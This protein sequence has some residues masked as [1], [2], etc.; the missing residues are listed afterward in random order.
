VRVVPDEP[1]LER[2]FDYLADRPLPVGTVVRV[3]LGPRRIRGWVVAT[4][5]EPAVPLDRLRPL[6]AVVGHGPPPAVVEL[7]AWAARRWAGPRAALLR[8][9]SP[10]QGRVI[11]D[12]APAVAPV[13]GPGFAVHVHRVAPAVDRRALVQSLVP[14]TGSTIVVVPDLARAAR[15]PGLVV[16]SAADWA[17]ARL[18]GQTIVGGRTAAWAPVP[19]LAAGVVLDDL[20]EALKDDRAPTWHA[21]DVL[22]ER[23]ARA[24]VLLHVISAVPSQEALAMAAA[25]GGPG[26]VDEPGRAEERDGWPV[27]EVADRRDEPPGLGLISPRLV[28]RLRAQVEAGRRVLCV[29][30][31]KGRA[32][33]LACAQC[34]ALARCEVCGGAVGD[35][36]DGLVCGVCAA[37]RPRVCAECGATRLKLLRPGVTRLAE[38]LAALVPRA[39][40]EEVTGERPAGGP[41]VDA[42]VVVGTEALLYRAPARVGLVAFLDLDEELLA[43]RFRATEHALWLIARGARLVGPRHGPGRLL[44][45]TRLPEHPVVVAAERGDPGRAAEAEAARRAALRFPPVTALAELTGT[46]A[47]V[48][49]F[50]SA[51]AAAGAGAGA[52]V[53][54]PTAAGSG[55]SRALVRAPDHDALA[56]VLAAARTSVERTPRIDVDP[57]RV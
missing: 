35:D 16:R 32:R 4:G 37:R 31:R 11:R 15:F 7:T 2:E 48:A 50:A 10:D 18:G 40:V 38:E 9:A 36:G 21:R 43:P 34:G 56:A 25:A 47:D 19:D 54:G 57:L 46:T 53:L 3:A 52:E 55:R 17:R 45:Q 29:L 24:G 51:V 12:A 6:L 30:N 41:P 22:A 49:G 23:C 27:V 39:R 28:E 1:G 8:A 33:L 5:V 14:A 13:A 26:H 42:D 20:D 44:L